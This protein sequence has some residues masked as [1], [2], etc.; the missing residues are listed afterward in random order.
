MALFS[1]T[2][3]TPVIAIVNKDFTYD[4]MIT[5][6]MRSNPEKLL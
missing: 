4:A 1:L 5:N 3:E 6:I 2:K